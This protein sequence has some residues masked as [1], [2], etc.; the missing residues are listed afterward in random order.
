[1]RYYDITIS[2]QKKDK[3]SGQIIVPKPFQWLYNNTSYTSLPNGKYN[4]NALNVEFQIRNY[5]FSQ[6]GAANSGSFIRVW[7]VSQEELDQ[8]HYLNEREIVLKGGMSPGLPLAKP[9]QNGVLAVGRI[10]QAFG[11]WVGVNKSLDLLL[12]GPPVESRN[13]QF[14]WVRG[15]SLEN[16]IKTT[17]QT[18]MPDYQPLIKISSEIKGQTDYPSTDTTF[19]DF[20]QM[21]KRITDTPI[22]RG[23]KTLDGSLYA[24]VQLTLGQGTQG[25]IPGQ[26][27][28]PNQ[29]T[30]GAPIVAEN[31]AI[32][33]WD[34]TVQH[35]KLSSAASPKIL[36][37]E[38]FIGQPTWI[39]PSI[40]QFNLVLRADIKVGDY[41]RIPPQAALFA[42]T[43]PQAAVPGAAAR[44]RMNFGNN[45]SYHI[46][47]VLHNGNFRETGAEA[48]ISTY[49]A[50]YGTTGFGDTPNA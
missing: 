35:Q 28:A 39:G 41:V 48:W 45:T 33:V 2:V 44:D 24:G 1:M 5:A 30:A 4:P 9:E 40:I 3:P 7:G 47:K 26:Q 15:T 29:Q 46:I 18:A 34:K 37:Y 38:D 6:P 12:Y 42:T 8:A 16:A 32:L 49:E 50:T 21:I 23:I 10:Y 11:N 13:F 27:P 25:N 20:S 43:N 17:L 19:Y 36:K 14:M 22:N 31:K